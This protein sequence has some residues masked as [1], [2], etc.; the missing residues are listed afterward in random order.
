MALKFNEFEKDIFGTLLEQAV[1]AM[2]NNSCN[3]YPV[4]VTEE[5]Q[6]DLIAFINDMDQDDDYKVHLLERAVIGKDVYFNDWML[7]SFLRR[8]IINDHEGN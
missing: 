7:M 6:E 4:H 8:K 2:S 1:D 3:D 5:N